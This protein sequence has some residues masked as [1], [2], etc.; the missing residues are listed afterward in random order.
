MHMRREYG[1]ELSKSLRTSH[2]LTGCQLLS[3]SFAFLL[4]YWPKIMAALLIST[5]MLPSSAQQ[6]TSISKKEAAIKRKADTLTP[7]APISV[8]CVHAAE[9]YGNFV[10]NDQDSLTFYDIDRKANMTLKYADV[11][12]IK[13]GYGGYNS[14]QK[15][16]TDHTRAIIVTAAVIA[17]IGGLIGAAAAAK[18]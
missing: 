4:R 6:T 7:N 5:L 11:R 17:V 13:D 15:T 14:L 2:V 10:S 12:K 8:L 1:H 3:L 18:N 16:H 9:E